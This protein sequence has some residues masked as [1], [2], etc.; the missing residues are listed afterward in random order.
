M[1]YFKKI[2]S[3]IDFTIVNIKY[4]KDFIYSQNIYFQNVNSLFH[5]FIIINIEKYMCYKLN[6]I[7]VSIM[8]KIIQTIKY[9]FFMKTYY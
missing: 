5:I 7:K 8:K 4:K 3:Y 2:D 9:F 1:C 6:I